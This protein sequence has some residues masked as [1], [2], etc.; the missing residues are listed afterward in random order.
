MI[1]IFR[2]AKQN[3]VDRIVKKSIC[4]RFL[5]LQLFYLLPSCNSLSLSTLVLNSIGIDMKN[6]VQPDNNIFLQNTAIQSI[7]TMLLTPLIHSN[8]LNICFRI[9]VV[10]F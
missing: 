5:N 10:E 6:M 2:V 4:K 7:G 8:S 1:V 3:I 9:E